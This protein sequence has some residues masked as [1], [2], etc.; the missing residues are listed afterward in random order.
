MILERLTV[1]PFAVNCYIIGDESTKEGMIVDAGDE[2]ERI[3]R[4]VEKLGLTIPLMVNTHCHTDHVGALA[5]VQ[6]ATKAKFALHEA[7]LPILKHAVSTSMMLT[8]M[9][10]EEPPQPEIL[11]K[12]GDEVTVGGL[13]FSVIHTPGH[14]PGGICLL[15]D[16][17]CLTGD[18][19]FNMGIGR[20]D[21]PG[22]DY[23]TLMRSITTRLLT[24]PEDTAIYPG[25]GP[26]STIGQEK[27]WN[28]F[29]SE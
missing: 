29:F 10:I 23:D 17:V 21:F 16:N 26:E 2:P 28:P 3:L 18:T 5:S 7:E 20:F 11:L 1:G 9:P 15:Q 22:G 8:G 19:L 25:H 14:T 12:D 13:T 4:T 6:R 27:I 24:L